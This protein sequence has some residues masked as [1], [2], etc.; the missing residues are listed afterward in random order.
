MQSQRQITVDSF[1][2]FNEIPC[3]AAI[4]LFQFFDETEAIAAVIIISKVF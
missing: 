4:K 3:I 1:Q 2:Y